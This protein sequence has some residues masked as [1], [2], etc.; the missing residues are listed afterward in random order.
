M[1]ERNPD[2]HLENHRGSWRARLC[3]GF[4]QRLVGSRVY[5]PL[6]TTDLKVARRR[7]D[8]L[9]SVLKTVGLLAPNTRTQCKHSKPAQPN[10]TT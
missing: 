6:Q 9:L 3:I 5:V 7:R 10:T 1:R 2:H 4:D 8:F